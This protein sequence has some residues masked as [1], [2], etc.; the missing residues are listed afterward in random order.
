MIAL[1]LVSIVTHMEYTH[2]SK[3]TSYFST[4]E[5]FL[6]CRIAMVDQIIPIGDAVYKLSANTTSIVITGKTGVYKYSK[7]IKKQAFDRLVSG[8]NKSDGLSVTGTLETDKIILTVSHTLF[9]TQDSYILD[10]ATDDDTTFSV[11]DRRLAIVESGLMSTMFITTDNLGP[12]VTTKYKVPTLANLRDHLIKDKKL[13]ETE[14]ILDDWNVYFDIKYTMTDTIVE[15]KD[16]VMYEGLYRNGECI[17][18]PQIKTIF[19]SKAPENTV[20]Y[21][22][23]NSEKMYGYFSGTIDMKNYYRKLGTNFILSTEDYKKYG[24]LTEINIP[25]GIYIHERADSGSYGPRSMTTYKPYIIYRSTIVIQ[26]KK[27]YIKSG[28]KLDS[29]GSINIG[30]Y[31]DKIDSYKKHQEVYYNI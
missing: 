27:L 25:D 1:V 2:D 28:L 4:I 17:P 20:G 5:Y 15:S 8:L 23:Y 3:N 18:D 22:I 26:N 11:L 16:V 24:W 7:E 14:Y 13:P 29:C 31:S 19:T 10:H 30:R 21:I 12:C 9:D 6:T